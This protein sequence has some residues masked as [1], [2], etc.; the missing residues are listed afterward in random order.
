MRKLLNIT[1]RGSD[2]SADTE[3]EDDVGSD[4][5][6]E[7]FFEC[8][9]GRVSRFKESREEEP[10]SDLN[11]NITRIRRRRR[12]SETFRAQYIDSK[13]IRI[14]VGTWNVGGKFHLTT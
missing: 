4:S 9:H 1:P 13:E 11:D 10:P 14:C 5:E 6:T 7:E 2:Y 12:K 3:E 8:S